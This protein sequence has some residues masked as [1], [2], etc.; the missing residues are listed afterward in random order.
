MGGKK[1]KN[2]KFKNKNYDDDEDHQHITK[3][4]KDPDYRDARKMVRMKNL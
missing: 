4:L 1:N 2:R 3:F